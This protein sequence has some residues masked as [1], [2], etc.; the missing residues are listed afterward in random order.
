MNVI[1]TI[2][3][4]NSVRIQFQRKGHIEHFR[5]EL[6]NSRNNE[7]WWDTVSYMEQLEPGNRL[8]PGWSLK[9]KSRPKITINWQKSRDIIS[10]KITTGLSFMDYPGLKCARWISDCNNQLKYWITNFTLILYLKLKSWQVE[11]SLCA[12]SWLLCTACKIFLWKLH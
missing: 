8:V 3:A 9:R 4:Q 1:W 6:P 12:T 5:G 10:S 11:R 7:V 2:S